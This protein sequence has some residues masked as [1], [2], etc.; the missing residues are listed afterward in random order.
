MKQHRKRGD[1]VPLYIRLPKELYDWVTDICQQTDESK[2]ACV[3]RLLTSVKNIQK[4]LP[5]S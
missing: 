4:N 2:S 3:T 1:L 5:E